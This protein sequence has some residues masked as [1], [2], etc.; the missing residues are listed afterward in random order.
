M[1]TI[2]VYAYTNMNL[3]DDLFIKILCE[4]Y[5]DTQFLIQGNKSENAFKDIKNI[6]FYNVEYLSIRIINKILRTLKLDKFQIL[7]FKE[8]NLLKKCDGAVYIGGSIFM[9]DNNWRENFKLLEARV[10]EIKP[11]YILGCNFGPFTTEEYYYKHMEIFRKCKDICFRDEFSYDLFKKLENTRRADDIVYTLNWEK[12]K[13]RSGIAISVIDLENRKDLK[14]YKYDY[15]NK[16][17]QICK[18][19]IKKG[20]KITLISF[21]ENEGDNNA[22]ND[23]SKSMYETYGVKVDIFKYDG[24]I[25]DAINFLN[26]N[27]LII[28]TRFHSMIIGFLLN[29]PVFPIIYSNKMFEVLK[30]MEFQGNSVRIENIKDITTEYITSNLYVPDISKQK[31]SAKEQFKTLDKFLNKI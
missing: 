19:Y 15:I 2:M 13:Q 26:E 6:K 11:M 1:K 21:C 24:N 30:D 7:R 27:R 25:D 18:Q 16:I 10:N 5:P 20:E 29:I 3:G 14:K 9:E 4:R 23:I 31:E 17:K 12:N 28:G 22:I 8:K